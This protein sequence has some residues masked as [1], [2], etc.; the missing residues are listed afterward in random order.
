MAEFDTIETSVVFQR[1]L[2]GS[3]PGKLLL[4]QLKQLFPD[5][6]FPVIQYNPLLASYVGPTALGVIVYEG[7]EG[8]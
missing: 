2:N 1:S 4:D 7:M 8:F 5:K 6:Q 3:R